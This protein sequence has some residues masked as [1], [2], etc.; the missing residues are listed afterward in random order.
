MGVVRG[1]QVH[2]DGRSYGHTGPHGWAWLDGHTGPHGWAW[3]G[4]QVHM[5]LGAH[6][7]TWMGVVRCIQVHMDGR[8]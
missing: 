7:S 3:L 1:T 4:T 2:M 5:E 6:R 8:S